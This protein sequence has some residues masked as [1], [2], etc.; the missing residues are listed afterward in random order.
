[1]LIIQM[2]FSIILF[3][4][5]VIVSHRILPKEEKIQRKIEEMKNII[6][7]GT[8]AEKDELFEK[9]YT[10]CEFFEDEW[11]KYTVTEYFEIKTKK[12]VEAE[13]KEYAKKIFSS[14]PFLEKEKLIE[15]KAILDASSKLDKI[16]TIGSVLMIV[17]LIYFFINF[18]QIIQLYVFKAGKYFIVDSGMV[19]FVPILILGIVLSIAFIYFAYKEEIIKKKVGE[20]LYKKLNLFFRIK[21][22]GSRGEKIGLSILIIFG[23]I[24]LIVISFCIYHNAVVTEDGIYATPWFSFESKF[25]SWGEVNHIY[26]EIGVIYTNTQQFKVDEKPNYVI[27]LKD[28][29]KISMSNDP[30]KSWYGAYDYQ[31]EKY[32]RQDEM[33]DFIENKTGLTM[34]DKVFDQ[35]SEAYIDYFIQ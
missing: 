34:I 11:E 30:M 35:Q 31:I 13:F 10:R 21:A 2:L 16:L 12:E 23:V 17:V 24:C 6:N 20:K 27:I 14:L 9:L 3:I 32:G 29:T 15:N 7:S 1:M 33:I 28:G 22:S 8:E 25:F 26:R 5:T 19:W 18:F 4:V